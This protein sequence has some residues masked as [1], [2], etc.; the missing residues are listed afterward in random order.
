MA[1][2]IPVNVAD[3]TH[4]ADQGDPAPDPATA[5][6]D[7]LQVRLDALVARSGAVAGAVCL[8]DVRE[9]VLRLAAEVGLSDEGCR[10]LRVTRG[11]ADWDPP[12]TSLRAGEPSILHD[13]P[14]QPLP[15]LM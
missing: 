1:S 15:P 12:L 2:A 8:F 10:L 9:R 14:R 6:H 3:H 7:E 13:D 11:D 5:L 4:V